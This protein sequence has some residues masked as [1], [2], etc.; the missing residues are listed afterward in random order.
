MSTGHSVRQR[1]SSSTSKNSRSNSV[2]S[3]HLRPPP[4]TLTPESPDQGFQPCAA[5]ASFL[6]YS[7]RNVILVLHH[8]TLA[9]ERR[10]TLHIEDVLWIHVDNTSER[11]SGRLAVSYD[12]GNTVIVWDIL[13]G[14]EVAR[15]SSYEHMRIASFLRNGNISFGND[16]GNVIL[17]EPATA[18]HISARTIFDPV[19][20]LA[21]S[22]DCKTFAI[23]YLNGSI[24]V[25]TLRPSF[26]ILHTLTTNRSPS[27][28]TG[29][30]WHGSSSKQKTDML[31][32]QTSDG[33]LRVWSVPKIPHQ[34]LQPTIIRVLQRAEIQTPSLY[35]FA[36][37]KSGRI[38]QYGEGET[39]AWDVRTK[40]VTFDVIPVA[41]GISAMTSYGPTATLFT[42]GRNHSV[43][44]YDVSPGK[45]PMEVASVQHMPANPPPTPP[46]EL[47]RH[48][49]R[50][51]DAHKS[52][53]TR[54]PDAR[55]YSETES[56]ADDSGAFEGGPL[57]PL[58]K[59]AKEMDTQDALESEI[60][61]KV[62]PLSPSSKASSISSRSSR[63]SRRAR[64]Y[65][66][67]LPESSRA[68]STAY[69]GT[70]F[71]LGEPVRPSRESVSIRSV[72]SM[73]SRPTHNRTSSLR[74]EIMRSPDET[75]QHSAMNLF[76]FT[77][78]RLQEVNFRTPHYGDGPRTA[79][80]LQREML[81][82][83]FGWNDD[84]YSLIH[85]ELSRH[86]AGS[87]SA[88]LLSK[89]LG[90]AGADTMASMVGSESMTSSDWMLLALN[91]IGKDSQKKVGEAFV[92]RLLEKG[93]IHPAVAILLGLGEYNDAIEVYVSQGFWME[94]LLLACLQFPTEWGRQSYL[95]RKWGEVAVQQ[96][97]AMLAVR[98]FSCAA[99]E[100]SSVWVS[101]RAQQEAA[102][103]AQQQRNAE[104][105]SAVSLTSPPI[106]PPSRSG[107]GRLTA[108][109][110]SLK[111]ITTFGGRAAPAALA[112]QLG[113]TPIA[114]SAVTPGGAWREPRNRAT[115]DPSSART[116]T[117]GEFA[118]RKRLPS[119]GEIE[120]AKREAADLF[121]PMT[122]SHDQSV[123]PPSMRPH[124]R[125]S[126]ASSLPEP[127]TAL[128][129][130]SYDVQRLAPASY[131]ENRLPSPRPSLATRLRET[132]R[133]ARDAGERKTGGL[134]VE[135]VETMYVDVLTPGATT[136]SSRADSVRSPATN[137]SRNDTLSPSLTEKSNKSKAIDEYIS[138][139]EQA[140]SAAR[141][142]R[143]SSRRRED[144][145]G[146][147][148]ASRAREP[149][150][151]RGRDNVRYIKSAKRSPASPIPMSPEEIAKAGQQQ[152]EPA[153]TDD[154]EFYKLASPITSPVERYLSPMIARPESRQ[155]RALERE[156][157]RH[158][159]PAPA[160][161]GG[162]GRSAAQG[163]GSLERS[164]S[165][166][167]ALSPEKRD[168]GE[169]D[170]TESNGRRF[171]IRAASANRNPEDL[172]SRRA[173]S[174]EGRASSTSRRPELKEKAL[175][176]YGMDITRETIAEDASSVSSYTDSSSAPRRPP[177]LSRRELAAKELEDR[178][179]SLARRPSAPQIPHPADLPVLAIR[180]AM[181]PRSQTELGDSPRST[182][183]PL[184]RSQT[185]EPELT[186]T[187][188][189]QDQS[190]AMLPPMGLPA[191]PRA[192]KNP[193][194]EV[195]P[196]MP[197][198]PS[199]FSE[200]SSGGSI[201]GSALSQV[202][203]SY[204]SQVSSL[205]PNQSSSITQPSQ[206]LSHCDDARP[207]EDYDNLAPL[208][209]SSIFGQKG[210]QP[211]CSAS[212]PLESS[213]PGGV[214]PAY[215]PG[216]PSTRRLSIRGH[217]RKISPPESSIMSLTQPSIDETIHGDDQQVIIIGDSLAD[218]NEPIMLPELQHLAGPPPPP[219]VPTMFQLVSNLTNSDV[220]S[221]HMNGSSASELSSVLPS[222]TYPTSSAP[223]YPHPMER[224]TTASPTTHRRGRGSMSE[225]LGSQA[226][227]SQTF[228]SRFRGVTDRMRSQSRSRAKSPPMPTNTSQQAPY[229]TV[230][231]PMPV[232]HARSESVSRAK[233]PYEMAGPPPPPSPTSHSR[234]VSFSRAKSPYE[235]AMTAGGQGQQIP[236]PPPHP[237]AVFGAES[238]L[239][240]TA[241][242]PSTLP[243]S[244]SGST[245]GYRNPREVRAN[246]PPETLQQGVYNGGFL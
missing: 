146:G 180:P 41:D 230:L 154:E 72:S 173:A 95:I 224:S 44:Q 190:A 12:A 220:I 113:T 18:E 119:R 102:F 236:P 165:M 133:P 74:K 33:D 52:E 54:L 209:P 245:N 84:I 96:G 70:E 29:L 175:G 50:R 117:P 145:R 20:A 208:L 103:A 69:N 242:A 106:S 19:T 126:N 199:N 222:T 115:R 76:P 162:R 59:I 204:L 134:A 10:F 27:R 237:P 150:A 124:S 99:A 194:R 200:L 246:M 57:S 97:E 13:T 228:G 90:D 151:S 123:P 152:V 79:E 147:R 226:F 55:P 93:D 104:P 202:T 240:E 58:Q 35:W 178:R 85:N 143:T 53:G 48:G 169:I 244:R 128:R 122:A 1:S 221:V 225:T 135:I 184:S 105:L 144:N 22:F 166:P 127:A 23:G 189:A 60:R 49:H 196:S 109:N 174:R 187:P 32:T 31:A 62:M 238:N 218:S 40:R 14:G 21:P 129:T 116:A 188:F 205:L 156:G 201:T 214:H 153:T 213:A 223:P 39:R 227:G 114:E 234:R 168:N 186:T 231:P 198:I 101:P 92:Q 185:A 149:S 75:T 179:L 25:A 71:S 91:S 80:L 43:Q 193:R 232:H 148:T 125:T 2:A 64:R 176:V 161:D 81:S 77:K 73:A 142:E 6:L 46:T 120:R 89:W 5:T 45:K 65:L 170:E 66:Y 243:S 130:T 203:V 181:A 215:K 16:Q 86:R 94:A 219:P 17:F 38:V 158:R 88:V 110:A 139:V 210:A 83:V 141:H 192:M 107:S 112:N 34:D 118:K 9:I 171:R 108:K 235:Q 160:L 167:M 15:F 47:E 155:A 239:S 37:S 177:G 87:A 183:P 207:R 216:L 132:S 51:G 100:T 182:A 159:V 131:D 241:I 11:G 163:S 36:W 78:A 4:Q 3:K 137:Q 191:T 61:D 121:T 195:T 30:S 157:S 140:R 164:P 8:D 28:I 67:D 82:T 206:I 172:Q 136:S 111:L 138:S 98:C 68:S 233:S 56:S 217:V 197:E 26:T 211:P 24:L 212:V 63:E 42:L 229:E 7:Q